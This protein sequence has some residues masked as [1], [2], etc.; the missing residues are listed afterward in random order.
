M[1]FYSFDQNMATMSLGTV[2]IVDDEEKLLHLLTRIINLEGYVVY[3]APNLKGATKILDKESAL[4][5]LLSRDRLAGPPA[6]PEPNKF[7]FTYEAEPEELSD[8]LQRIVAAGIPVVA[9]GRKKEGLEE[10]FLKVG[11]KEIS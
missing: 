5:S 8:L 10:V 11:A 9:F 6:Q 4:L 3:R 2:L 7:E 1:T